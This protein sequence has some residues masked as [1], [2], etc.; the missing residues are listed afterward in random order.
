[1]SVDVGVW[2]NG[3]GVWWEVKEL[4]RVER[5]GWRG[6]SAGEETQEWFKVCLTF[7]AGVIVDKL[8][9]Y[10]GIW[11]VYSGCLGFVCTGLAGWT[12]RLD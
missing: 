10:L 4:F 12:A 3:C 6:W 7:S 9:E 5:L 11:F 2:G 8:R 1:M